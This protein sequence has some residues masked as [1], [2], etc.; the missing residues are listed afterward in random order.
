MLRKHDVVNTLI[1][2]IMFCFICFD[3]ANIERLVNMNKI[4]IYVFFAYDM[5]S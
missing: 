1:F 5:L 4:K 2:L 3:D